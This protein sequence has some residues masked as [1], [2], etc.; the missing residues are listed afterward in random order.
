MLRQV[1]TLL[2]K[3]KSLHQVFFDQNEKALNR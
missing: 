1:T 3:G 2:L